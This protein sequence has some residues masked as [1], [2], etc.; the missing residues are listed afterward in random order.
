MVHVISQGP[1]TTT[2]T[3]K[4]KDFENAFKIIF[5]HLAALYICLHSNF[6][7]NVFSRIYSM[8]GFMV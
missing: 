3:A 5:S 1:F 6:T 7:R 4:V 8:E 2:N